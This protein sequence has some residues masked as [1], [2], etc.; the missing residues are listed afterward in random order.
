MLLAQCCPCAP[1]PALA[2]CC[3]HGALVAQLSTSD[4]RGILP[5]HFELLAL[6]VLEFLQHSL[7]GWE[8]PPT[9]LTA[10]YGGWVHLLRWPG[11]QWRRF[12]ARTP[13]AWAAL[14][15]ALAFCGRVLWQESVHGRRAWE[16]WEL[17]NSLAIV[18]QLADNNNMRK[19]FFGLHAC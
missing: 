8:P 15:C 7:G 11:G 3:S 17:I 1:R 18:S 13:G 10:S 2:C 14:R 19:S 5:R 12:G 16:R 6:P 4:L 9:A